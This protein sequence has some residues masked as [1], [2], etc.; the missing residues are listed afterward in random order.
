MDERGT[1]SKPGISYL[2]TVVPH[3]PAFDQMR[4]ILPRLLP[5]L[6]SCRTE[7]IDLT[8]DTMAR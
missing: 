5:K 7:W 6:R 8:S 3:S 2:D 4:D 1:K